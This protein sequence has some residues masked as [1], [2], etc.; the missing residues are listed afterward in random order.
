[1]SAT[2]SSCNRHS[3]LLSRALVF[4]FV[5]FLNLAN[6]LSNKDFIAP[7][8]PGMCDDSL[9]P[10]HPC[11]V[12]GSILIFVFPKI[13]SW[14]QPPLLMA[15]TSIENSDNLPLTQKSSGPIKRTMTKIMA[16]II[17]SIMKSLISADMLHDVNILRRRLLHPRLLTGRINTESPDNI[18]L[19]QRRRGLIKRTILMMMTTMTSSMR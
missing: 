14:L 3:C 7:T 12:S 9:L 17:I 4:K 10:Y 6:R 16:I 1:M 11:Y 15:P 13:E 5:I 18:P 2:F 19:A 8:S